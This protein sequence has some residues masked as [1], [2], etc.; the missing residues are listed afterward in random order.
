[1]GVVHRDVSPDN[2][3]LT[4]ERSGRDRVIVIDFGVAK[5]VADAEFSRTLLTSFTA[6]GTFLGKVDYCSPEQAGDE[7]VDGRSDLYSLGLVLHKALTGT[8]PFKE[9]TPV[10]SLAVRRRESPPLLSE[11][12]PNVNFS[13]DLE[14]VV[15]K[16]LSRNPSDRYASADEF[17]A[18]LL[19][20]L[21][22]LERRNAEQVPAPRGT[23]VF[24]DAAVKPATLDT[25]MYTA[26]TIGDDVSEPIR[27]V[28]PD[29][30]G[31]PADLHTSETI[32]DP[33]LL[34][35]PE[36][37]IR[38]SKIEKKP[39][40][41]Y[42]LYFALGIAIAC[43][44]V[45]ILWMVNQPVDKKGRI[46]GTSI[47]GSR[48]QLST[49]PP[50]PAV[51]PAVTPETGTM[52]GGT[53]DVID[54]GEGISEDET[55]FVESGDGTSVQVEADTVIS[56]TPTIEAV[57]TWTPR[58][59]NT[60]RP[61]EES[62]A[63]VHPSHTPEQRVIPSQTPV[64]RVKPSPSPVP[65]KKPSH[66]PVP[67]DTH[68][69][70]PRKIKKYV[71][72]PAGKFIMGIPSAGLD[73]AHRAKYPTVHITR[74]FI[75]STSEVTQAEWESVFT[76]NPSRWKGAKRP[77][78]NVT[79]NDAVVYCNLL[80]KQNGLRACYYSDEQFTIVFSG[81]PP[82]VV[83]DKVFWDQ[84]ANGFRLPTEAEWEYACRAGSESKLYNG[85]MTIAGRN[86]CPELGEIA[87]YTGNSKVT[88]IKG[89]NAA[90]WKEKEHEFS[91]A[92]TQFV[93]QKKPNTWGVY[94][95]VGNVWE[96]VWDWR[97]RLPKDQ[98]QDPIGPTRGKGRTYRGGG[99]NSSPTK[100]TILAEGAYWQNRRA[101]FIGFRVVRNA[102]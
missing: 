13:L 23:E 27:D 77:V 80:S 71:T 72:I 35:T 98:S 46:A 100:C 49:Q 34:K 84:S 41:M 14:S 31:K 33:N 17:K 67:V 96:W 6:V 45:L 91:E 25:N 52:A 9:Q 43:L 7:E 93:R 47:S 54:R 64:P 78:E 50:P 51:T 36:P 11:V 4:P 94:D 74:P 57:S 58:P 42:G 15:R 86:N 87:W 20:V 92:A 61:A 53:I 79:W 24:R 16:S 83:R 68:T 90:R 40:K 99:W 18:A 81:K 12:L 30:T 59:V 95:M 48:S 60:Q 97:G 70:R 1:M 63:G 88:D 65:R 39:R 5:A 26:E 22:R 8:V 69:P 44:I 76:A 32:T 21:S 66:T 37:M 102:P 75:M 62:I 10:E 73:A 29:T 85:S 82:V 55:V 3:L 101:H 19:K 28:L 2:L 89:Q 56:E 38:E